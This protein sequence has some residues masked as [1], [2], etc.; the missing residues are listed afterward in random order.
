M[1]EGVAG[2]VKTQAIVS[3]LQHLAATPGVRLCALVD[4]QTGM[5][6][7]AAGEQQGMD[8]LLE[9]ARDYWRVHQRHG[10]AFDTLGAAIGIT[11]L[12]E[13]G[14]VNLLPCGQELVLVTVADPG[15]INFRGWPGRLVLLRSLLR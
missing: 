7:L 3:E 1:R 11:V 10:M 8:S 15:H 12:H 2:R 14:S 13:A 6:W 4:T 5:V 9:A